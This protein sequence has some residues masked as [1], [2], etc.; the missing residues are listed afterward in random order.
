MMKSIIILDKFLTIKEVERANIVN[1]RVDEVFFISDT[2]NMLTDINT[3]D[4]LY[5]GEPNYRIDKINNSNAKIDGFN[6][7]SVS[8]PM[9]EMVVFKGKYPS[10][11]VLSFLAFVGNAAELSYDPDEDLTSIYAPRHICLKYIEANTKYWRSVTKNIEMNHS[12]QK[13]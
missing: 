6:E 11:Y 4:V 10:I 5:G 3:Y 8:V 7:Y 12:L 9:I 1:W 2:D 13:I